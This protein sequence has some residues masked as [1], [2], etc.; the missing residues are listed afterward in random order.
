MVRTK[1]KL[2]KSIDIFIEHKD[3]NNN[4]GNVC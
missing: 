2:D 1:K 4:N 3:D